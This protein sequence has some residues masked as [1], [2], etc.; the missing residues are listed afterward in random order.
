MKFF[1]LTLNFP[2]PEEYV[3]KGGF[4][5]AFQMLLEV[6]EALLELIH[7]S[8]MINFSL[9]PACVSQLVEVWVSEP[10]L[11]KVEGFGPGGDTWV[12]T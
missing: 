10:E 12:Q 8:A 5:P 7:M 6:L 11:F 2:L 4:V 3:S 9:D 1:E